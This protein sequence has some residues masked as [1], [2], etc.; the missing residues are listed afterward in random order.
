MLL[1]L[2]SI[3]MAGELAGELGVLCTATSENPSF[4]LETPVKAI[5]SMP[6]GCLFG[7]IDTKDG[8]K[9]AASARRQGKQA[10]I[11]ATFSSIIL[12]NRQHQPV[13]LFARKHIQPHITD[14]KPVQVVKVSEVPNGEVQAVDADAEDAV[15]VISI[16]GV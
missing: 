11:I 6:R 16:R 1:A 4:R 12:C 7:L 5:L 9:R 14:T 8:T 2:D 3:H 10:Q 13:S 15:T